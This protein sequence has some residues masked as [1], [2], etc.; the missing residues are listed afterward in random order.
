[1]RGSE[2]REKRATT[3]EKAG[4]VNGFYD[5]FTPIE[6]YAVKIASTIIFLRWLYCHVVDTFK[7][8]RR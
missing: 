3:F 1:M 8:K 6:V 5:P 4:Y 2:D 7:R